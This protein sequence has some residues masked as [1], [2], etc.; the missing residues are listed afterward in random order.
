MHVEMSLPMYMFAFT[1]Q[2]RAEYLG[3]DKFT[4]AKML[5]IY[6]VKCCCMFFGVPFKQTIV[7]YSAKWCTELCCE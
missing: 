2:D 5:F 7:K 6:L 3:D 1:S 4:T